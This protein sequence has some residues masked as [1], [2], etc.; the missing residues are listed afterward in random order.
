LK[1]R[2]L[3][4]ESDVVLGGL[5]FSTPQLQVGRA[6]LYLGAPAGLEEDPAWT[7]DGDMAGVRF[8]MRLDGLGDLDRDGYADVAIGE[9]GEGLVATRPSRAFIYKGTSSGLSTAPAWS[10][11]PRSRGTPSAMREP[12]GT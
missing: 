2:W 6:W 8:A 10:P 7:A 12:P 3:S 5:F 4:E 1:E 9:I 11:L